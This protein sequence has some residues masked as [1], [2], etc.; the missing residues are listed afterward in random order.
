[1]RASE[2]GTF[3]AVMLAVTEGPTHKQGSG[4]ASE[5]HMPCT[6]VLAVTSGVP[7][8]RGRPYQAAHHPYATGGAW[9]N[10]AYPNCC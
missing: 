8:R 10:A 3:G 2:R 1:M 6:V 9:R 5:H 4:A 7:A